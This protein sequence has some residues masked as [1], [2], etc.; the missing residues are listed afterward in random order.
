MV[1]LGISSIFNR[2]PSTNL[3]ATEP[4]NEG[5]MAPGGVN[6]AGVHNSLVVPDSNLNHCFDIVSN[7]ARYPEFLN[8]YKQVTL[9]S[10]EGINQYGEHVLT[11]R[12]DIRIPMLLQAFL[13]E[14]HYSLRLYIT[15]TPEESIMRWEQIDGPAIVT[16]NT[17]KWVSRQIGNDVQLTLH[18]DVGYKLY[19]PGPIKK[20]IQDTMVKDSL[21]SIYK[22]AKS[23][24]INTATYV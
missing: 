8:L 6:V 12:Y 21:D 23:L 1:H 16:S 14:L 15:R 20:K 9:L 22:R 2:T 3:Q 24:Q 7:V 18:M 13:K 19:V 10:D 17:G 5:K 11:A 4:E